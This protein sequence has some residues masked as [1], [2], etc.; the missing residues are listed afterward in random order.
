MIRRFDGKIV[1]V[2]GAGSGVGLATAI[3][4]AEE[5]A[6]VVAA[7]INE[8]AGKEAESKLKA[9]SPESL[10]LPVDISSQDSVRALFGTV[11]EKFGRLDVAVNNAGIVAPTESTIEDMPLEQFDK[12]FSVNARGL[13]IC[14]QAE[15]PLMKK[16]KA[17]AIVNIASLAGHYGYPRRGDY[18]TSK[19][20]V[21]GL[22][23][24]AALEVARDGIRVT[25]VSP[26]AIATP[27]LR[28]T[29]GEEFMRNVGKPIPI[30][31]MADPREIA[32]GVLFMASDD[33]SLIVGHTLHLDG[34]MVDIPRVWWADGEG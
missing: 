8:L 19:H 20:A 16:R 6:V 14:L 34:G 4:F 17:G 31:R 30:G 24:T 18:C 27:L 9:T 1:V 11:E 33:A 12:V 23:R 25:A 7:E 32:R 15:I 28:E 22:T 2:T 5:G 3:E 21:M 13:L 26:G 10:F 29:L